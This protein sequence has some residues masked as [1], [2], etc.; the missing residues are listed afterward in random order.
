MTGVQADLVDPPLVPGSPEWRREVT[1]SKVAA[2]LGLSPWKSRFAMYYDM[3]G[4][5]PPEDMTVNQARGHYLEH[6]IGQWFADQYGVHLRPGKCWRSREHP[7]MV[8]TPDRL[9][10]PHRYSR[11]PQAPLEIKTSGDYDNWCPDGSDEIP[12]YYRCQLVMQM[13]ALGL[14]IGHLAVLL[15]RLAFRAYTIHFDHEEAAWM[16]K[17]VLDFVATLPGGP[18]EQVPDIDSDDSTYSALRRLHPL[19]EDRE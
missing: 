7:W 5:L 1:A 16:R 2:I 18:N 14:P 6:A 4:L 12:P 15:P 19:V 8:V 17:E 11:T 3:A 10:Y 9:I 13:D